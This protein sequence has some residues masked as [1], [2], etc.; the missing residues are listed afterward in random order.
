MHGRR[1][2]VI[3]LFGAWVAGCASPPA[4]KLNYAVTRVE[5]ASQDVAMAAAEQAL[6][7]HFRIAR[8]DRAAG[9]I[10]CAPVE[11]QEAVRSGRMGDVLG[12]SRRVRRVAEM[13]VED[14]GDGAR[15]FC[16]ILLQQYETEERRMF[17]REHALSDVPSETPAAGEA[18]TLPQQNATWRTRGRDKVLE[19]R[20]LQ[21]VHELVAAPGRPTPGAS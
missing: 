6:R 4:T 7:E 9:L 16:K 11:S 1:L 15:V 5:A 20:I 3:G 2:A 18:A 21:A 8:V 19:R 14:L 17:D 13:R 12:A 10:E